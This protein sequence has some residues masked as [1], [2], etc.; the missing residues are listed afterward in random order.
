MPNVIQYPGGREEI[1]RKWVS[2]FI[3]TECSSKSSAVSY[4]KKAVSTIIATILTISLAVV[5]SAV[6]YVAVTSYMRPQAGLSPSVSITVGAS[7]FTIVNAQIVNTGGMPFTSLSISITG[8]SSQLQLAYSSVISGGGGAA[9]IAIRGL[10][11]GPY[12]AITQDTTV[13]GNLAAIAGSSYAVVI[14]GTL[15]NGATYSQ[16]FGVEASP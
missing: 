3:L 10:S 4:D 7:G 15:S 11:G 1:S 16:A 13:S 6:Y 8:G 9:T 2:R 5:G 14:D 12:S